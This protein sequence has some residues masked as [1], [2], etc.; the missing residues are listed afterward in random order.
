MCR[1]KRGGSSPH[2]RGAGPFW[3]RVAGVGGVIPACA[4]SRSRCCS[5]CTARWGHP[6]MRG[7]QCSSSRTR[8]TWV[9]SSPHA[10]GA[11][12][13]L[14]PDLCS[15]GVIPACAGSSRPCSTVMS[16]PWG[17]PR[18]RGEQVFMDSC[19]V[20]IAGSSPHARGAVVTPLNVPGGT[21]VIPAC[22]GSSATAT[23]GSG[24]GRGHPRMRGEQHGGRGE[25][26]P[27][28]GSSPHARGAEGQAN[29]FRRR[30]GVIP[31]CAGS[32]EAPRPG[33]SVR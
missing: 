1:S 33:T 7:E 3:R 18:M 29:C 26:V 2:A 25:R 11:A 6:R 28:V 12:D 15:G 14:S 5:G 19:R 20:P 24:R 10:R 31:A 27:P 32:S 4:G 23:T 30:A 9:G 13:P 22:A 16:R 21:G 8:R 17:H